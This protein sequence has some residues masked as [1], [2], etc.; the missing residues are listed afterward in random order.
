MQAFEAM[1]LAREKG[2]EVGLKDFA[3]GGISVARFTELRQIPSS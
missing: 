3:H 1:R 2:V